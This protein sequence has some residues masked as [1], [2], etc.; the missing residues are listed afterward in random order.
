[1]SSSIECRNVTKSFPRRSRSGS[2]Y[3]AVKDISITI[4][5]GEF[6][7]LLGPS[8]CGKST[9]LH[10]VAGFSKPT[11]G[12][13]LIDG[14]PAGG[15]DANR[16]VVF[17]SD[18][19]LFP[20]LTVRE[21]I[22]YGPKVQG[23]D[24]KRRDGLVDQYM[25]LVGL[26][27]HQKKYPREISGGMKQRVQI[28]RVLVNQPN[29]LLMDEPFGALDAHTRSLLQHELINIWQATGQTALFVTHDVSEAIWLSDRII[30]MTHGP[31]AG[32]A[33]IRNNPFTRPRDRMNESFIGLYN[34]LASELD[35]P[36]NDDVAD[37]KVGDRTAAV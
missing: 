13:I 30:T 17:Q 1:M 31:A 24:R 34:E 37:A 27:A 21:N 14:K 16:G 32:I 15:P 6:V 7:C 35:N 5:A 28:A 4:G 20:W 11:G 22:E 23:I 12:Q 8:G 26:Q 10:M 2:D 19:A 25:E 33:S 29:V 3:T 36:K 9:L 18:I